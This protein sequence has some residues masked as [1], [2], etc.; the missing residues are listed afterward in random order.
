MW[1]IIQRFFT[2]EEEGAA[3]VEMSVIVPMIWIFIMGFILFFF[4]LLDMGIVASE[5]MRS[6]NNYA[7]ECKKEKGKSL[8]EVE[9]NLQE[10][11]AK[12]LVITKI[13]EVSVS[14][15]LDSVTAKVEIGFFLAKKGLT[16]ANSAKVSIN[17]REEWLRLM[18]H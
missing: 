14:K 5:T 1:K 18:T 10:R 3:V 13:R 8:R 6:A 15:G 9:S 7:A 17:N 12:R 16:F 4:F 2:K 11:L